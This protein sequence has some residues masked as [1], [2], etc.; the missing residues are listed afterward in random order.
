[1]D[2]VDAKWGVDKEGLSFLSRGT[3]GGGV[4]DMSNSDTTWEP[5]DDFLVGENISDKA[6]GFV[7]VEFIPV[8]GDHAGRVL[9]PV[10]QHEE[11][12]VDLYIGIAVV[13]DHT[14]DATHSDWGAA[15][16]VIWSGRGR[17]V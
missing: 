9:T 16:A 14:D 17:G 4:A 12:F 3:A 15:C 11:A 7:F 6:I 2:E 1:M 10:L 5:V 13:F 8:G